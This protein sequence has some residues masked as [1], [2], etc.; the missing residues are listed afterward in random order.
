MLLIFWGCLNNY[1][2]DVISEAAITR[3]TCSSLPMRAANATAPQCE[4]KSATAN[5]VS[6]LL[7][8]GATVSLTNHSLHFLRACRCVLLWRLGQLCQSKHGAR[9]NCS[10]RLYY[11]FRQDLLYVCQSIIANFFHYLMSLS[12]P[13][14]DYSHFMRWNLKRKTSR[15]WILSCGLC[16]NF[17]K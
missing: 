3:Q 14:T 11:A 13:F 9:W 7:A 1:L 8:A 6:S 4:D 12:S 16:K 15:W 5:P 17:T 10:W 2:A